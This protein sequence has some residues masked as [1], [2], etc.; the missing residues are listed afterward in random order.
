M[1]LS[2]FHT[3]TLTHTLTHPT[4]LTHT[5]LTHTP[6]PTHTSHF[7]A[8]RFTAITRLPPDPNLRKSLT[9]LYLNGTK[10]FIEFNP[11]NY[12]NDPSDP[13]QNRS[14]PRL[15][16]VHFHYHALCC[17]LHDYNYTRLIPMHIVKKRQVPS[18]PRTPSTGVYTPLV[19]IRTVKKRQV[20]SVGSG[21]RVCVNVT[22]KECVTVDTNGT[23]FVVQTAAEFCNQTTFCP[24]C[25]IRVC[26]RVCGQIRDESGSGLGGSGIAPS[27]IVCIDLPSSTPTPTPTPSLATFTTQVNRTVCRSSSVVT[28]S[29]TLTPTPTP[30]VDPCSDFYCDTQPPHCVLCKQSGCQGPATANCMIDFPP[31]LCDCL[32]KR[33]RDASLWFE[34]HHESKRSTADDPLLPPGCSVELVD[35]ECTAAVASTPLPSTVATTPP[36][37][38]GPPD[39]PVD[40]CSASYCTSLQPALVG[41]CQTC[42]TFKCNDILVSE[43]DIQFS[44]EIC[45]CNGVRKKRSDSTNLSGDPQRA[46]RSTN[47]TLPPGYFYLSPNSTDVY[48]RQIEINDSTPTTPTTTPNP[49]DR[50]EVCGGTGCPC[51]VDLNDFMPSEDE[52]RCYPEEDDFNPCEDLLGNNHIL[53]VAI[54]IVIVV[55]LFGNALVILVFIGYSVFIRRAKQDLF[56]IHFL[57]FNLAIADFLMGTYLF[58]IAVVD[59]YTLNDFSSYDIGWRTGPGCGFTGFCA[60]VSTMMSMYTLLVITLERTYTITFVMRRKVKKLTIAI[61]MVM[62]WIFALIMGILPL[63]GISSYSA[64]AICLPF[65]VLEPASLGYVAFLLLI[66]GLVFIII[67]VSYCIIF[68]QVVLSPDKRNLVRSGAAPAWKN[69]LKIALRMAALVLTNFVCWFPIALLGLTAAFGSSLVG[70]GAS[71]ILVVFVFPLNACLNPVLYSLSSK[72]FRENLLLMLGKCGLFKKYTDRIRASRAGVTPS[73]TSNTSA[74]RPSHH[75]GTFI[76]RIRLLRRGSEDPNKRRDSTISQA[77]TDDTYCHFGNSRRS[78]NFSGSSNEDVLKARRG[79]NFSG[80][81]L[82]DQPP[83]GISNISYRSTSPVSSSRDKDLLPKRPKV[84]ASSLGPVPEEGEVPIAPTPT[85]VRLNPAYCD[86]DSMGSYCDKTA[87]LEVIEEGTIVSKTEPIFGQ[88]GIMQHKLFADSL[89]SE[90]G[91]VGSES[92][93]SAGNE[94]V[95]QMTVI[96]NSVTHDSST[97]ATETKAA[98]IVFH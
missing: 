27:E 8:F 24:P 73:V 16:E 92:P 77:L 42:Q 75:G 41:F 59:L 38:E 26:P 4:L 29:P 9:K 71:K 3:H 40:Y 33:K 76:E 84:S 51:E 65:D 50:S 17:Q 23:S 88:N 70:V 46:R 21:G 57:Y 56:L 97:I 82:E 53:R 69:E 7:S 67:L 35:A 55:A 45:N 87:S 98:Q 61:V 47:S 49:T 95:V 31:R 15:E 5:L 85:D 81:S 25:L 18:F 20:P 19:P 28:A 80:G 64:V 2:H 1:P 96:S 34:N 11:F 74:S 14:Y 86:V 10:T 6:S 68:Y 36:N 93:E 78:S 48:C 91:L 66:T 94:E 79:S 22:T 83:I 54:W 30:S 39:E 43:C 89:Q 63:T 52:I 13:Y 58:I 44:P 62:G 12:T 60:I 72:I 37:R 90:E 32:G